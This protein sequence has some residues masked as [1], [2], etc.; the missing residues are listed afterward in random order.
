M[1]ASKRVWLIVGVMLGLVALG[2]WL[3]FRW[4]QRAFTGVMAEGRQYYEE[5][6][7]LGRSL[8][9]TACVDTAFARHARASSVSMSEQITEGVFLEACLRTGAPDGLCDSIPAMGNLKEMVRFSA[10]SVEQCRARGLTDRN[11]PRLLQA[12]SNHCRRRTTAGG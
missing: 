11:C 2:S 1:A 12:V 3:G 7:R 8:T 9:A 6:T 5:G 4:L 10:W